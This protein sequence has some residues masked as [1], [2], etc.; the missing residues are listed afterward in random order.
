ML[1]AAAFLHDVAAFAPWQ[2]HGVDHADRA[3]QLIGQLLAGTGFPMAK[4]DAV[5]GAI[6]THMYAREPQGPEA[7]YLHDADAL[8]WLARSASRAFSGWWTQTAAS[9]TGRR[10]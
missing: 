4:I 5:R 3:A 7:L 8:D 6:R 9:R 1:F 10:R 2:Q